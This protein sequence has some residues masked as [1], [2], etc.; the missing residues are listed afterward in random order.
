MQ[1]INWRKKTRLDKINN[2]SDPVTT[3]QDQPEPTTFDSKIDLLNRKLFTEYYHNNE[4][5]EILFLSNPEYDWAWSCISC[6]LTFSKDN[7]V[8]PVRELVIMNNKRYEKICQQI[9]LVVVSFK[10]YFTQTSVFLKGY[11]YLCLKVLQSIASLRHCLSF[12]LSSIK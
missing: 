12:G 1:A 3:V 2:S 11:V 5:F 7:P 6:K 9:I 4:K 8:I 10:S